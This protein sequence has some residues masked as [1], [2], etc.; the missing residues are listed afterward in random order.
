MTCNLQIHVHIHVHV[1]VYKSAFF[2][3]SK[4]ITYVTAGKSD[5]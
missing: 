2:E 3:L 1:T 5:S 4:V